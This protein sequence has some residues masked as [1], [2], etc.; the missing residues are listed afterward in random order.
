MHA[1]ET[2]VIPTVSR[3]GE[4]NRLQA[5]VTLCNA[6]QKERERER[7]CTAKPATVST[8]NSIQFEIRCNEFEGKDLKRFM[9]R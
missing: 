1:N 9:I 3:G 2:P 8:Q 4:I 6:Q 7:E 5:I